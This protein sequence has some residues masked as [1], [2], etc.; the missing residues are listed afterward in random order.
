MIMTQQ[1]KLHENRLDK[2]RKNEKKQKEA[3]WDLHP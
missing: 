2:R 1:E 3:R